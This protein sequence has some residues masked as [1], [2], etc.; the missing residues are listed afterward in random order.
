[1]HRAAEVT[2]DHV[3]GCDDA[4]R[5]IVVRA[6]RV[7]TGGDDGEVGP[8]V[9][10]FEHALDQLAVHV[11]LPA[12][13]EGSLAHAPRCRRPRAATR[14]AS[15]S[16]ASLTTRSGPVTSSARRKLTAGNAGLQVEHEPRPR[17]VADRRDR[18][19]ATSAATIAIGSSVS[20]HGR[21]TNASGCSTTRGAS[22]CGITR[23]VSPSARTTSMVNR[24]SGIAS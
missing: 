7:R 9:T 15:I 12:A 5:R 24:S 10:G 3:A 23:T 21:S 16:A 17:L 14:N 11:D 8:L 6:G 1:M 4:L 20:T 22:S 13:G 2:Q 18:R 19:P